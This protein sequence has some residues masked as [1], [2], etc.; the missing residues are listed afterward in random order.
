[1]MASKNDRDIKEF[2]KIK[3]VLGFH[4]C[5]EVSHH[6]YLLSEISVL[7]EKCMSII[8]SHGVFCFESLLHQ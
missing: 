2:T 4:K 6:Y 8:V 1:M 3:Q 5:F 7:N